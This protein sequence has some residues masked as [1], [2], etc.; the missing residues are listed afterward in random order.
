MVRAILDGRKTQT[1]RVVKPQ[2]SED[3]VG[4]IK[5]EFYHPIK[6]DRHGNEYPGEEVFG[7]A[8]ADEGRVCP[9]GALGDRLWVKETFQKDRG[10]YR[11]RADHPGMTT[12]QPWR[13]SIFMPRT[14]SRIL[15]EITAVRV[16]R[17]QAITYLDCE[18][19][20]MIHGARGMWSY[21]GTEQIFGEGYEAYKHLWSAING[22]ES[23]DANP[24]VWVVEFRKVPNT[25]ITP[26]HCANT[27]RK[28]NE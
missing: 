19:E 28:E 8:N 27:A 20:G 1:R 16:E 7:F 10:G 12:T 5:C 13:P 15:L 22:V 26:T 6:I 25:N 24:C 23:W 2:P 14:L 9:Y 21:D 4:Q 17:L 3:W 11:F 18:A